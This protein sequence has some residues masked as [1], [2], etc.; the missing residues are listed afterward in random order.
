MNNDSK[1]TVK[2]YIETVKS[3]IIKPKF[4]LYLLSEDEQP[5]K[6]IISDIID[7][8]GS[9]SINYQ[10]GQRR[11]LNFSL[12]N[13]DGRYLPKESG[14]IWINTK[15]RLDLGIEDKDGFVYWQ[16]NG[17]FV[18][19]DPTATHQGSD[20]KI[21]FQC[22]DKFSLLDGTLGGTIDGVYTIPANT[23]I[24][25]AIYS[26]LRLSNGKNN[27]VIDSKEPKL[28]PKYK[29][30][31]TPYTITKN[32][33]GTLGEIL[34]ELANMIACDIYYDE[35][36]SLVIWSGIEDIA[37]VRKPVLWSYSESELE[38]LDNTTTYNF[39]GVK[40][41]ITVVGANVNGGMI[42]SAIAENNNPLSPT[43]I[44]RIGANNAY[45]EDANIY[46]NK[47]AKDRAEYELNK[48]SI[49]KLTVTINS[50]YMI[51]L[52]V[53]NCI[54]ITDNY[55]GFLDDRFVI[56][57]INIPIGID[58]KINIKCSNVGSLPYY[59]SI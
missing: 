29:G 19:S 10:Q 12:E 34:I 1:H 11:S 17:I 49:L 14:N 46:S 43:R 37:N 26:I 30:V 40:N 3:E 2:K 36:G 42:Y 20:K 15:F 59:P 31:Q 28:D 23:N 56:Q 38:Y 53:N 35:Y 8:S 44:S 25:N 6:E 24:Y 54:N 21:T 33:N 32:A 41:R 52:D 50:T 9:L 18:V 51:H 5:I 27:G 16:E 47:L 13:I 58:S 4:R 45:I 55:F 57:S 39:A 48:I 22:Y 7:G